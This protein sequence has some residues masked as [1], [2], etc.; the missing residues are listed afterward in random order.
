MTES[1]QILLFVCLPL[2]MLLIAFVAISV[3]ASRTVAKFPAFT[4][5][6]ESLSREETLICYRDAEK[7]LE[8]RLWR[9]TWLLSKRMAVLTAPKNLTSEEIFQVAPNLALGLAK[10]GFRQYRIHKEGETGVL[11]SGETKKTRP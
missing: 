6:K 4:V 1:A 9:K 3:R 11:T 7:K 5:C 8:F 10:F 2:L